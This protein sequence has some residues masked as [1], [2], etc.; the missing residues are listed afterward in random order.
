MV[1]LKSLLNYDN[2]WNYLRVVIVVLIDLFLADLVVT[3]LTHVPSRVPSHILQE[4]RI[5]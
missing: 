4:F 2:I 1:N 5:L 3:F